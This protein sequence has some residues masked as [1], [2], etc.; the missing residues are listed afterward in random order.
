MANGDQGGAEPY[1]GAGPIGAYYA[2]RGT[3]VGT[4]LTPEGE[5]LARL[6]L[7]QAL[8]DTAKLEQEIQLRGITSYSNIA[9]TNTNAISNAIQAAVNMARIGQMSQAQLQQSLLQLEQLRGTQPTVLGMS[10]NEGAK[11]IFVDGSRNTISAS[12]KD[13]ASFIDRNKIKVGSDQLK[14]SQIFYN[15]MSGEAVNT[16]RA[17]MVEPAIS[18]MDNL[19]RGSAATLVDTTSLAKSEMADAAGRLFEN[20]VSSLPTDSPIRSQMRGTDKSGMTVKERFQASVVA[21]SI[22]DN[23]KI[24][25]ASKAEQDAAQVERDN[26]NVRFAA[27]EKKF[28]QMA[29]GLPSGLQEA[30]GEVIEQNRA[31]VEGGPEAFIERAGKAPTPVAL[32]LNKQRLEQEIKELDDP[33]DRYSQAIGRYAA[34]VPYFEN[35]MTV[36][37]FN[38]VR[39]AVEYARQRPEESTEWLKIVKMMADN[40]ELDRID[41]VKMLQERMRVAG[42]S[43]ERGTTGPFRKEF[44][45]KPVERLL[46]IGINRPPMWKYFSGRNT[47]EQLDAAITALGQEETPGDIE[48]AMEDIEVDVGG[49]VSS[50]EEATAQKFA[51]G[52]DDKERARLKKKAEKF[53]ERIDPEET[54][55]TRFKKR[56][57]KRDEGRFVLPGFEGEPV[58]EEEPVAVVEEEPAKP[59]SRTP[60]RIGGATL[61]DSLADI[62]AGIRGAGSNIG[63]GIANIVTPKAAAPEPGESPVNPNE[64]SSAQPPATPP[65]SGVVTQGQEEGIVF[66]Q[67]PTGPKVSTQQG[68]TGTGLLVAENLGDVFVDKDDLT[69][70]FPETKTSGFSAT[71][72]GQG[73]AALVPRGRQAPVG[74]VPAGGISEGA[75]N[76]LNEEGRK[77][78]KKGK[79]GDRADY[80]PSGH[81]SE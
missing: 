73:L 79:R 50:A 17:T 4:G 54:A 64:P 34:A 63:Q 2:G 69:S 6:Q 29:V 47:E 10:F 62:R 38:D 56:E 27:L 78:Y 58:V 26:A 49:E 72:V 66:E 45:T 33:T 19:R 67:I 40:N 35:Y 37:G 7:I 21:E 23:D 32:Q 60:I 43:G 11:S 51:A 5:R 25:N 81:V 68:G 44:L 12:K 71:N 31:I 52:F 20:Y 70:T 18:T 30:F 8:N 28:E 75:Y 77:Y 41:D 53:R 16:I 24:F 80:V 46:G 39:K 9:V 36:M 55:K 22:G 65:P 3:P 48:T 1:R 59:K 74:R 61:G 76:A 57:K 14:D 42:S 13:S 15:A